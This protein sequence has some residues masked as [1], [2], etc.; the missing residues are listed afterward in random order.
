MATLITGHRSI[1]SL[2]G[3]SVHELMHSWYQMILGT[4]E[5]LYAWMDEGF[6]SFATAEV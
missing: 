1:G 6:T 5:A 2:V 3:V 4:N